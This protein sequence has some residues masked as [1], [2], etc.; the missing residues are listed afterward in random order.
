MIE[1]GIVLL[2]DVAGFL[3]AAEHVALPEATAA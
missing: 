1:G 2:P 3:S